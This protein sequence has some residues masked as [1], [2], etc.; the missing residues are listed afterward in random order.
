MRI[1][2]Y[3]VGVLFFACAAQA[4]TVTVYNT[5]TQPI[6]V[7]VYQQKNMLTKSTAYRINQTIVIPAG[8]KGAVNRP[9]RK[10]GY[11]REI[12]FSLHPEI[13]RPQL[14][15]QEFNRTT[16][17][18]IGDMQG[19]S[20]YIAMEKGKLKGFNALEW[21]VVQPALRE[22][23]GIQKEAVSA[24]V[25]PVKDTLKTKLPGIVDNPYKNQVA[26]VRIG[27]QLHEGERSYRAKRGPK[28][29]A[30]LERFLGRA[31]AP[32]AR[33]PVIA[34]IESGG[35]YR[36]MTCALGWHI[37]AQKI[38]LLDAVTY[39]VGLSGSTWAIGLWMLS[40]LSLEQAKKQIFSR[41]AG[42][43]RVSSAESV[44]IAQYLLA[45]AAFDQELTLIDLYAGLLANALLEPFQDKR[46]RVFLSDQVRAI[47]SADVPFP[48]YTA[49][50]G[51]DKAP[52]DWYEFTPYEIGASWLGMYVP[53]WA[54]GRKFYAGVSQ[55]FAPEQSFGFQ[56]ATF[57]SAIAATF[58][59]MKANVLIDT[60]IEPPL[61]VVVDAVIDRIGQQRITRARVYNFTAGISQSPLR[62]RP[63]ISLV[64]AGLEFNL[65][66]PPISGERPERYADIIVILDAS[67]GRVGDELK[68]VEAY[69]R[70]KNLKFPKI[71]YAHIAERAVSI[72]K[73]EQ[74]ATV[75]LII[76][77]PRVMDQELF[78]AMQ[79]NSLLDD[80]RPRITGFDVERCIT[81]GYCSTFNMNYTNEQ[82]QQLSAL[83][84]F[85]MR[86]CV[87]SIRQA[88]N[89]KIDRMQGQATS[90]PPA[91]S[92]PS[93]PRIGDD[94]GDGYIWNDLAGYQIKCDR[95]AI[96][97]DDHGAPCTSASTHCGC[98]CTKGK[99]ISLPV[100]KK[101]PGVDR[102]H[103]GCQ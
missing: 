46:H 29:R 7:A 74:D 15:V 81:N 65:P 20:V 96:L 33:V 87:N 26:R 22:L 89:W 1:V 63:T 58:E 99:L 101:V 24:I 47:A 51:E 2:I 95:G 91:K 60:Q 3:I 5:V 94:A 102:A 31:L 92:V 6:Y 59:Q 38:G 11:D 19:S 42:I 88:V 98:V 48:I 70:T 64:D 41:M 13:L 4:D 77:M 78:Q 37:G 93:K 10:I 40:G 34:F 103:W 100:E 97:L 30:A 17:V 45:K 27:N 71:E 90:V 50:R 54:Y 25:G 73:D 23:K 36:A 28:V 18:N 9:P 61:D 32:Q 53:S 84:E 75:P 80:L 85:N 16:H 79:N 68:K 35:G 21:T 55:D 62:D 52:Q 57:G 8:E 83:T 66:Y 76:Y 56:M 69:A 82:A 44:L 39:M 14:Q 67:A 43:T 49:V 86:A 12:A 72:F